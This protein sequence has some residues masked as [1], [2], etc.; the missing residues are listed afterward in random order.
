MDFNHFKDN[1]NIHLNINLNGYKERQL[2]RRIDT[3]MK[4]QGYTC[5]S[6]YLNK[7]RCDVI[8]RT[9]FMDKI[10]IN[11]SEFFR[12]SDIFSVAENTIIPALIED[13]GAIRVWSAACSNGAEPYSLAMILLKLGGKHRI[14][15]TDMDEKILAAARNA[16]YRKELLKNVS[17]ER[18]SEYFTEVEGECQLKPV[19]KELINFRRHD[20]LKD[21]YTSG[22]HLIVC[23]NVIIYFTKEAQQEIYAK[24]AASLVSGG[25]LFIGATESILNYQELG[26]EKKTP[27]FYKKK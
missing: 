7:L 25:V 17:A 21:R 24:F 16:R 9:E 27:W 14:D 18:L 6:D 5:Y 10:T 23:R 15:A 3:L 8:C 19:V 12:N 1:V 11:V 2:K 22:Y 13:F 4:Y 26:F 20:L